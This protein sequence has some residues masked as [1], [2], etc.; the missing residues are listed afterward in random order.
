M[1]LAA[2]LIQSQCHYFQ[3]LQVNRE[4]KGQH[5][6][7]YLDSSFDDCQNLNSLQFVQHSLHMQ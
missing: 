6:F 1:T 7:V 4:N 2:L 5:T 3:H